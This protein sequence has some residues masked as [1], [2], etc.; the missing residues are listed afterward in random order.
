[1]I[2]KERPERA[3]MGK[4]KAPEGAR[5]DSDAKVRIVITMGN[6]AKRTRECR[7]Q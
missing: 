2:Q 7:N 1:M 5:S 4:Q 3:F 6:P